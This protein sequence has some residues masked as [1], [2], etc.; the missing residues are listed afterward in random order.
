MEL[1]I[2]N[3]A[4]AALKSPNGEALLGGGIVARLPPL[5]AADNDW[6]QGVIVPVRDSG[7]QHPQPKI[8]VPSLPLTPWW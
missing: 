1:T 3:D 2:S 4:P 8:G 6:W 7:Q 5:S